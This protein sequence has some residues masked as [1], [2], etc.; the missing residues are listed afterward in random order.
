MLLITVE[1]TPA[2]D[3]QMDTSYRQ[4]R[5]MFLT[6]LRAQPRL[7]RLAKAAAEVLPESLAYLSTVDLLVWRVAEYGGNAALVRFQGDL[8]TATLKAGIEPIWDLP[9][10]E[11]ES[12]GATAAA[13]GDK[14]TKATRAQRKAAHRRARAREL[15][16]QG[17]AIKEIAHELG[18]AERTIYSDLEDLQ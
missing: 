2:Y 17:L 6:S 12:S 9:N 3:A 7:R 1:S 8:L 11:E 4:L 18:C 14:T 16:E 5:A 10:A 13:A 15:R